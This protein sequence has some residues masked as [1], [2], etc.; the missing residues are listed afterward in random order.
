MKL[1]T[2][3]GNPRAWKVLIVAQYAGVR[4]DV[5]GDFQFLVDNRKPEFYRLSP[6][7][8][9]PVLM[10]D[11]GRGVFEST[12]VARYVAKVGGRTE[13]LGGDDAYTQAQVDA[14]CDL[15]AC[16][17]DPY[18]RHT[19]YP[20]K[21]SAHFQPD[22]ARCAEAIGILKQALDGLERHLLQHTF[23]V[24]ERITLA[25]VAMCMSLYWFFECVF[26]PEMLKQYRSLKRWFLTCVGQPEFVSVIGSELRLCQKR[27]SYAPPPEAEK[28]TAAATATTAAAEAPEAADGEEESASKKAKNAFDLLPKS[29]FNLDAAKRLYS[30]ADDSRAVMNQI[31]DELFDREGYGVYIVRY[32]Y[33]NE[34]GK[35]F[36]AA[37]LLNG[38]FQR[39]D[40]LRKYLFGSMLVFGSSGAAG[41]CAI[42]GAFIVRGGG[43]PG[44]PTPLQQVDDVNLYTWT[45]ADVYGT[46]RQL[47]ND[48]FAWEGA[49]EGMG[50][51][52]AGKPVATGK[53]FK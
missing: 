44:L 1:L 45:P 15:A 28:P 14:F 6:T 19:I 20:S 13:L 43:G 37:N 26:D 17:V 5:P 4:I 24:G 41:S 12:A 36:M 30:N 22:T 52:Y 25:D 7:G 8:Q 39:M 29:A 48:L 51:E 34:L 2:Y 38:W 32:K 40:H 16:G 18:A 11:D 46:H 10:L 3:P 49:F 42:G 50:A 9:V 47:V 23:L 53:N 33:N 21:F 35:T 27:P 31:W